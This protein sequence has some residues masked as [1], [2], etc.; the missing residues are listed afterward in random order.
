MMVKSETAVV[1][2][3]ELEFEIPAQKGQVTTL[4][5]VLQ[6]AVTNLQLDQPYRKVEGHSTL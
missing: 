5:S 1:S 4:E 3:P 6:Q 2:I